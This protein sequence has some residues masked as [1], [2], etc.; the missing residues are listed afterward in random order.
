MK[1]EHK[2]QHMNL[3]KFYTE[4]KFGL[5]IDLRSMDSH[6]MQGSGLRLVNSTDG[7]QLE[8]EREATGTGVVN[9]WDFVISDS[10][11]NIQN[12]QL[13]SVQN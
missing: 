5:L 4:N 11:F 8:I 3:K 9:C 6:E 1:E 10:Q 2:P 13:Q 12:Q 7:I